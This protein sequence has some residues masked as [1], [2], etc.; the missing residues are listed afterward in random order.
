MFGERLRIARVRANLSMSALGKECGVTPQAIKKFEHNE[1]MPKSSV[2]IALCRVL[3]CSAEWLIEATPLDFHT[4]ETAPQGR[5]A[6]YW[7]RE[8]LREIG[9]L[10]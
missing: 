5:H 10:T 7:V 3:D 4:T 2:L 8:A 6:K 1:C 9:Y